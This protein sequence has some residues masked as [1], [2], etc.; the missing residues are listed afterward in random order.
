MSA[1]IDEEDQEELGVMEG[2]WDDTLYRGAVILV[3]I[4]VRSLYT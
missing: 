2:W 4:G 3:C 1:K